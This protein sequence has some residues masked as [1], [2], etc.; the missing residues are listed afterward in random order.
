MELWREEN[1]EV[2]K[3]KNEETRIH[4]HTHVTQTQPGRWDG[5]KY[6]SAHYRWHCW[7]MCWRWHSTKQ[8]GAQTGGGN[9]IFF[10]CVCQSCCV[11]RL[12][13]TNASTYSHQ[14]GAIQSSVQWNNPLLCWSFPFFS[15]PTCSLWAI[16]M[17]HRTETDFIYI[18]ST[19][20]LKA[21]LHIA[22]K[23]FQKHA[24]TFF[25]FT[26]PLLLQ[27]PFHLTV[28]PQFHQWLSSKANRSQRGYN[29]LTSLICSLNCWFGNVHAPA[30]WTLI[31]KAFFSFQTIWTSV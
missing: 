6:L 24:M 30:A 7:T 31:L 25:S 27:M 29:Y 18:L 5:V 21:S 17:S 13:L 10:L 14:K 23:I 11:L 22:A 3:G 20:Y 4:K 16:N 26:W 12:I 15:P 19:I 9:L 1:L 2:L 8:R 28:S